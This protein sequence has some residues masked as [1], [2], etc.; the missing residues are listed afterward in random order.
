VA[1]LDLSKAYDRLNQ[2]I[3]VL[4]LYELG[5]PRDIVMLFVYW[6]KRLCAVVVW[7]NVVSSVFLVKSGVRQ[8]G[9][10]SC[11]FFNMY[12]NELIIKLENSG[13][14]CNLRGIY[15]GCVLYADDILLISGSIVKLQFMLD[16]CYNFGYSN[17]L[18]F[19]AK[20]SV[21]MAFGKLC[22]VASESQLCIGLD[23][24]NWVEMCVYLGVNICSGRK[25]HTNCEER[26]RKFCVAANTVISHNSMLSEEC[27][28]HLLNRQCVPILM[29][30]SGVWS[31]SK[32][33]LRRISVSFNNA[34]RKVFGYRKFESVKDILRGFNILP[35]DF[36]VLYSKLILLN[37]CMTS[38]RRIVSVC[39]EYIAYQ[40]DV[41][42]KCNELDVTL[43]LS[44]KWDIYEA[45]WNSFVSI[46]GW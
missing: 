13:F 44:K 4:K 34:I 10:C 15:A 20:K 43:G 17:D 29:Y 19:N 31:C 36:H 6:F 23:R 14:G 24:I 9:V 1:A 21:C 12:I 11:W 25:F 32:E 8:G 33:L 30:A 18:M 39:S 22:D 42:M 2:C 45:I 41:V 28:M 35:M 3:L 37:V 27:Y 40:D 38:N 5:V 16:L 46:V 7:N 26:R